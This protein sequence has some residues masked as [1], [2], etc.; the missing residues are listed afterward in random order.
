LYRGELGGVERGF[1]SREGDGG[2]RKNPRSFVDQHLC[3]LL[4]T[5][6]IEK[7]AERSAT[8]SVLSG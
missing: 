6:N 7:A 2:G 4:W 3:K 8:F 5:Y 1:G